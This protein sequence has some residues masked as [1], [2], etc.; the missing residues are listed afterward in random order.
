MAFQFHDQNSLR[1][2]A[3]RDRGGDG[4]VLLPLFNRGHEIQRYGRLSY[5]KS[6]RAAS[7]HS[8]HQSEENMGRIFWR[9]GIFAPGESRTFQADART[10]RGVELDARHDSGIAAWFRCGDR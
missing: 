5:R 6:D 10:S 7:A 3:V 1:C 8:A 9:D 2:A 4:T